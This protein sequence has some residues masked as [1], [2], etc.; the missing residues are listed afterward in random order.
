MNQQAQIIRT[1]HLPRELGYTVPAR[2]RR[3][4]CT[5]M[6]WP[7]IEEVIAVDI[8]GFRHEVEVIAK[9]IARFEP[10]V[11]VA[12]PKDAAEAK[13]RMAS[14]PRIQVAEIPVDCC[15]IRDNGPIFVCNQEGE[16]AGVRFDFNGWGGRVGCTATR[17]MPSR[18][19]EFLGIAEFS[20]DFI[21]EGAGFHS[22]EKGRR[23]QRN[24]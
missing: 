17:E 7:P 22:T 8:E 21:C 14:E 11:M 12:D 15:W 13:Q 19:L 1:N 4:A 9:A 24:R 10:V 23:S 16:A 5:I 2:S 6:S 20:A 3:H 18:V